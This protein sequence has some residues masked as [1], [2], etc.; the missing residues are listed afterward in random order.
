M[1][2]IINSDSSDENAFSPTEYYPWF[3]TIPE[4]NQEKE[5]TSDPSICGPNFNYNGM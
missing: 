5:M 3:K 2:Q 4:T 1:V